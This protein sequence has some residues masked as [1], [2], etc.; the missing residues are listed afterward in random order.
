MPCLFPLMAYQPSKL[1]PQHPQYIADRLQPKIILKLKS[2]VTL[3]AS[4]LQAARDRARLDFYPAYL[5]LPCGSCIQCRLSQSRNWAVRCQHEL[6]MHDGVGIFLTLTYAPENLPAFGSLDKTVVPYFIAE[7]R[8]WTGASLKYFHCGE[9]GDKLSRPHYHVLIFGWRPSDDVKQVRRGLYPL[10]SSPTIE[11]LWPYGFC[12][13]GDLTFESAAYTARYATKKV[14]GEKAQ[15]HYERVDPESGEVFYLQPEY[16]TMSNRGGIGRS[17]I[18]KYFDEVYPSDSVLINGHL[19]QP[20]RF[21]D[22]VLKQ[23]DPV[24]FESVKLNRVAKYKDKP[25]MTVDQL[26]D[27]R[28]ATQSRFDMLMRNIE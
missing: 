21:Y 18:E 10:Y 26:A 17:W 12:P 23:R 2:E 6:Q 4:D 15:E 19:V 25:I 9:Y 14:T 3:S 28:R 16:A 24:L 22:K 8:R 11:A 1:H 20:P 27:L 13:F 7:L 5:E